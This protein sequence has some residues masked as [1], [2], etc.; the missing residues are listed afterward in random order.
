M[1]C[2][3]C[4]AKTNGVSSLLRIRNTA[5]QA[6]HEYFQ[7]EDF[8]QVHTPV[9]TSNDCEGAGEVFTVTPPCA[10]EEEGPYW[11]KP[12]HLTVSGQ[13][14]LEVRQN[15]VDSFLDI[16]RPLNFGFVGNL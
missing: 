4:K 10:P 13:L 9:L 5:S 8:I 16:F 3:G 15:K 6:V 2:V 12:V 1:S 14:H 7:S 11:D